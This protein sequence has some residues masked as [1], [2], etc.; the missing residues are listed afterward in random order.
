MRLQDVVALL[1]KAIDKRGDIKVEV[2]AI[3][4]D[5]TGCLMSCAWKNPK[6]RIGLIIGTGTNAC[7]LEDLKK[8]E[9]WDGNTKDSDHMIINTEWGAFGDQGELDFIVT[10]WDKRVDKGSINPGKQVIYLTHS[11]SPRSSS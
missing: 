3:L 4:N 2:A 11:T 1:K 9:L 6:C 5:T 10:K 7:Y 8:V